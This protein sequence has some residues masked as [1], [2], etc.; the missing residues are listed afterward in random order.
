MEGPGV[1][2]GEVESQPPPQGSVTS[3]RDLL[4]DHRR[5]T[6]SGIATRHPSNGSSPPLAGILGIHNFGQVVGGAE[7]ISGMVRGDGFYCTFFRQG[8]NFFGHSMDVFWWW[9]VRL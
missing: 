7:T 9:L 1:P 3:P 6:D 4:F 8:N 5:C 2:W